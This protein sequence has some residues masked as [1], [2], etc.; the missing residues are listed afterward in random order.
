MESTGERS[1]VTSE[2]KTENDQTRIIAVGASAGGLEALK[3][4]FE[5]I[6]A[7]DLNA[8]VVIQHLSPDYKSMMAELLKKNSRLPI[9]QID[10]EMQ[11]RPGH[12]HL[13]PPVNNLKLDG[14]RLILT[15]KPKTQTLNLPIDI[16][17]E[18]QLF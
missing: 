13:I 8:Y 18:S 5:N 10:H 11:V 16:F 17:F 4:F 1:I 9:I 2:S 7:S 6:E 15:E 12:V 14:D 3:A